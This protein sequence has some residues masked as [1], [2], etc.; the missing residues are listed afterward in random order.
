[1]ASSRERC[2]SSNHSGGRDGVNGDGW[3]GSM[4]SSGS[5]SVLKKRSKFVTPECN[6]GTFAILFMSST[7][8]N[9]N[10]LFYGCP[11][12]KTP[13]PYCKFFKWLDEYCS[14][15]ELRNKLFQGGGKQFDDLQSGSPQFD[16]KFRDLEDRVVGLE[17]QLRDNKHA[18]N[19]SGINSIALMVVAFVFGF[20]FGSVMRA[21][22]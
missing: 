20:V 14:E 21:L 5:G 4:G 22:D 13:A 7:L 2:Y 10:R 9:P 19:G 11:Y 3:S 17:L 16:L 18:S 15:Q 8:E 12:L 1:M 6:C